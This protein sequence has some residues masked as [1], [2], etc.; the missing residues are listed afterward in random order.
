MKYEQ[1]TYTSNGIQNT[2]KCCD[3]NIEVNSFEKKTTQ[4]AKPE[5]AGTNKRSHVKTQGIGPELHKLDL[6]T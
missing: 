1:C 3:K 4:V 2:I 5:T 6:K